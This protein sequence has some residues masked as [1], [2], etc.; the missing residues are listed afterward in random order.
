MTLADLRAALRPQAAVLRRMLLTVAAVAAIIVGILAM[1][2]LSGDSHHTAAP[3]V[4]TASASH[5]A[6]P[7]AMPGADPSSAETTC[8]GGCEP[9]H[10][11]GLA[12]CILA[13]LIVVIMLMPP[14]SLQVWARMSLGLIRILPRGALAPRRPPSLHR[15]SISRT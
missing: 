5:H 1:H 4:V 14:G 7:I 13:L 3:G 2:S 11:M 10:A 15:L 9:D 12:E 8:D 6:A